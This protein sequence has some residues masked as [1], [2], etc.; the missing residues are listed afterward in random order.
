MISTTGLSRYQQQKLNVASSRL[1]PKKIIQLYGCMLVGTVY[2]FY[3]GFQRLIFKSISKGVFV[4]K[5]KSKL[6]NHDSTENVT[7]SLG[8]T[9]ESTVTPGFLDHYNSM[10]WLPKT[11]KWNKMY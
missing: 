4:L 9:L 7:G 11:E 6:R 8:T 1:P 2:V 3:T 5:R 10:T